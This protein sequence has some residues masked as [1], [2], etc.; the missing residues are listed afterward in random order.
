MTLEEIM[1]IL[2]M[3]QDFHI[4]KGF[5]PWRDPPRLFVLGGMWA[6]LPQNSDD[7][8]VIPPVGFPIGA[9][10]PAPRWASP[11]VPNWSARR[12]GPKLQ[13]RSAAS[14]GQRRRPASFFKKCHRPAETSPS[15]GRKNCE[16]IL[17]NLSNTRL[18]TQGG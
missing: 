1:K 4:L 3:P 18:P 2:R 13:A 5:Q 11:V 15:H 9:A 14:G 6:A 10:A 8:A 16:N 7:T 17:K 12:S